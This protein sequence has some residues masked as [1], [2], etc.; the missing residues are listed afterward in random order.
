MNVVGTSVEEMPLH[1]QFGGK[2]MQLIHRVSCQV[3]VAL[4]AS[5]LTEDGGVDVS[6]QDG[7]GRISSTKSMK[8]LATS[9]KPAEWLRAYAFS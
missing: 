6:G 1:A 8:V 9:R 7:Y 3:T 4:P 2:S 5:W